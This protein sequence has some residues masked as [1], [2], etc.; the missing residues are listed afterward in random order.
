MFQQFNITI[1]TIGEE[2]DTF[3]F[4]LK[5]Q[6]TI[7]RLDCWL[8]LIA[9]IFPIY[10]YQSTKICFFSTVEPTV[11]IVQGAFNN[12]GPFSQ[13]LYD[14][15]KNSHIPSHYDLLPVRDSPVSSEKD[16]SSEWLWIL[17]HSGTLTENGDLVI[18]LS[19]F[20]HLQSV[21]I[22]LYMNQECQSVACINTRE[23]ERCQPG[24]TLS[25]LPLQL[26]F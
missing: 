26:L 19:I 14:L 20:F 18:L 22:L 9:V 10:Q 7:L 1:R 5:A 16:D 4:C 6:K 24:K 11:S 15:P 21:D 25:D 8:L 13:D 23:T 3:F 17:E 12:N 2:W